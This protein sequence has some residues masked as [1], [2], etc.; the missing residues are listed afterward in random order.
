MDTSYFVYSLINPW[1]LQVA[2]DI[3]FFYSFS[4]MEGLVNGE[5]VLVT[6]GP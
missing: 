5:Y 1:L 4:F 2:N 3:F 6:G